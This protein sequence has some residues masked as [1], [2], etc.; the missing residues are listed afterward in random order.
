VFTNDNMSDDSE[1]CN[2]VIHMEARGYT[3]WHI[4]VPTVIP[5]LASYLLASSIPD[6]TAHSALPGW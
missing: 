4:T 3:E 2:R 6:I 1:I 5:A